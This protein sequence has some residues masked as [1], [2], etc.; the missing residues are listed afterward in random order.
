[1]GQSLRSVLRD[2][3]QATPKRGEAT[4]LD[5][6]P[7]P[8]ALTTSGGVG[9]AE[10]FGEEALDARFP[11]LEPERSRQMCALIYGRRSTSTVDPM[12]RPRLLPL[13]LLLAGCAL[14]S[15]LSRDGAARPQPTE[16]E[17]EE[18]AEGEN[19]ERREAWIEER[20]RAA[21]DVDWRAL[22]PPNPPYKSQNLA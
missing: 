12:T 8:G 2:Q 4:G 21:P 1:M 22:Q 19:R 14:P 10:R 15:D 6:A 11:E 9:G 16:H 13:V 20:H 17:L 18:G 3:H 7:E 5:D